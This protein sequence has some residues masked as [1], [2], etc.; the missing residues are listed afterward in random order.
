MEIV[1]L[2][3]EGWTKDISTPT[4]NLRTVPREKKSQGSQ[5]AEAE[6][7]RGRADLKCLPLV[8]NYKSPLMMFIEII[9]HH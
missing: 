7:S 6:F 2:E 5:Q 4:R 9:S 1:L 8:V 3:W